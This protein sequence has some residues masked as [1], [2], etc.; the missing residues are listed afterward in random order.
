MPHKRNPILSENLCGLSR[1]VRSAVVPALENVALWHERDIS[2]SSVERMMVPDATATLAFMLDRA[3]TVVEGLVVYPERMAE[4]L[5]RARGLFFSEGVM[6]ALVDKGLLRQS[7]YEL[8][9]DNA[10]RAFKG[11]G[12][13]CELL[14]ADGR[15]KAHLGDDEVRACFDMDH[16][17]RH[18][19]AILERALAEGD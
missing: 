15:V 18:I 14:L 9:Q 7:A 11:E 1:V 13:L 6:L 10:M 8:V 12:E 5:S 2:H 17:L 16:A 19:P 3:R 4:N